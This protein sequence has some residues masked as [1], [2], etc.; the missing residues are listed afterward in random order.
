MG[1]ECVTAKDFSRIFQNK[2]ELCF[3]EYYKY[4]LGFIGYSLHSEARVGKVSCNGKTSMTFFTKR[5]RRCISCY[6][7]SEACDNHKPCVYVLTDIV[8]FRQKVH[9]DEVVAWPTEVWL[10]CVMLSV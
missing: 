9:A 5:G 1:L 2:I 4:G 7:S 6:S 8:S 3:R 10:S